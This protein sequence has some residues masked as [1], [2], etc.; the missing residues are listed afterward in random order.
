LEINFLNRVP[1][2]NPKIRNE[3]FLVCIANALELRA[4]TPGSYL[5][6]QFEKQVSERSKRASLLED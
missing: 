3:H 6:Y 2:F 1:F 4:Y 5:L